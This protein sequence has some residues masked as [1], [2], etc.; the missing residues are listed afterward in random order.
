[1]AASKSKL[2]LELL[3]LY[4][5]LPLLVLFDLFPFPPLLLLFS[6]CVYALFIC[7]A[8]LKDWNAKPKFVWQRDKRFLLA[9]GWRFGL[10]M[11]LIAGVVLAFLPENLFSLVKESP[12]LVVALAIFYPLVSVV[13]QEFLYRAYFFHRYS[14]IFSSPVTL[15]LVSAGLF[16]YLHIIYVNWIALS[17]SFAG[18][19]LFS[20][21]Y[22]RARS[23]FLVCLEHS[24]YGLWIFVVG[25]GDYFYI[26]IF[27][28]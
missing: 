12:D 9:I 25:L 10:L 8:Y 1:M 11:G 24:L 2:W 26:N 7:R 23:F 16:S 21:T 15:C 19:L 3:I 22:L 20:Y 27:A 6:V 13:P 5:C 4:C 28:A 14:S 17:M 18:G